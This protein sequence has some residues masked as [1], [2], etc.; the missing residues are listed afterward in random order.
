VID[1]HETPHPDHHEHAKSAPHVDDAELERR[2]QLERD[3]V[4]ADREQ[5]GS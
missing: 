2:T 1:P 5:F 3:E 4:Q